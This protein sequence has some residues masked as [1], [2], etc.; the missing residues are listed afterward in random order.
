MHDD[1]S[2]RRCSGTEDGW[3]ESAAEQRERERTRP[4]GA[5][6]GGRVRRVHVAMC[7]C[8]TRAVSILNL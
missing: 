2:D 6:E 8:H 1:R 5:K 3:T 7:V 4:Q